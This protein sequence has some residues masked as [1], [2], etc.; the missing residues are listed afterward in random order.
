MRSH[1]SVA[2]LAQPAA[3]GGRA[4]GASSL[5][6]GHAAVLEVDRTVNNHGLVGLGG[7]QVLPA[8]EILGGAG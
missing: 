3:R 8:A 2:D 1:L 5:P 7:R 4:A 6:A